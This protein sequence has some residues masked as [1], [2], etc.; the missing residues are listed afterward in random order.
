MTR[1]QFVSEP[2][3]VRFNQNPAPD[4]IRNGRHESTLGTWL[5]VDSDLVE[6]HCVLHDDRVWITKDGVCAANMKPDSN[7]VEVYPDPKMSQDELHFVI[8]HQ[9]QPMFLHALGTQVM[10]ASAAFHWPSGTL[11]ILSGPSQSGKSTTAFG[12]AQR[13]NWI[14]V[15][16]DFIGFRANSSQV[17]IVQLSNLLRL[18]LESAAFSLGRPT[19]TYC[20][21]AGKQYKSSMW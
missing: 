18:R 1:F 15:A 6:T 9:W 13:Q 21:I 17:T 16:D 8:L 2:L 3:Q 20:L 11:L 7:L 19:K 12:L 14:Q 4:F 5:D 10:H